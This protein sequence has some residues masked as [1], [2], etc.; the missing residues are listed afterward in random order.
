MHNIDMAKILILNGPNLNLLGT[1]EPEIY[2]KTTLADVH[3]TLEKQAQQLG[4]E[5]QTLQSNAEHELV[6]AIQQAKKQ[7]IDFIIINAGAFSHTSLALRDAFLAV[8][9][10]FIKIHISNV[11]A[12][13]KIRHTSYLS[14]IA[15]GIIGGFGT[16]SYELALLAANHYLQTH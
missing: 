16:Y 4:H 12:R 8:D 3:A 1:R 15:I 6:N 7:E 9:I 5:L 11:Y 2:G 10:P 13:E 14:D